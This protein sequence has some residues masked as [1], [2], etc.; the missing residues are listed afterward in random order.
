[1]IAASDKT[2][3]TSHAGNLEM[4]PLFLTVGNIQAEVRMKAT[5]HAWSLAA[6]MPVVKFEVHPDYQTILQARLWHKC[7]D[8]VCANLK[9][10]ARTGVYTPDPLGQ[11]RYGFT[12]IIAYIAD[13]LEQQLIAGV[14]QSSSPVTVARTKEFGDGTLHPPRDAMHTLQQLVDL[15]QTVDPWDVNTYQKKAK[16]RGLSGVHLPFWRNWPLSDP[17]IFLVPELLHAIHKFF[18]DHPLKW[19]K[20]VVG[21]RE[22]NARYKSMHKRVGVRHFSSGVTHVQQMTGREHRDIQRT[23]VPAIAGATSRGF[24]RAI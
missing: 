5:S 22:L 10:G 13:L 7:M 21:G 9:V 18:F 2:A 11:L 4:H 14:A 1:M 3:V 17:A 16:E 24:L 23:I 6:F 20:E 8:I 12:P 19:C 15:S